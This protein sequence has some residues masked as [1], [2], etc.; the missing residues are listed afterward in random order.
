METNSRL[1]LA[2]DQYDEL[3]RIISV[4][5]PE[6]IVTYSKLN[7][8]FCIKGKDMTIRRTITE[9][10]LYI[11]PQAIGMEVI[12]VN[13]AAP[14]I[15]YDDIVERVQLLKTSEGKEIAAK[16]ENLYE[17]CEAWD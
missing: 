2:E 9:V 11:I 13:T 4:L 16:N 15:L 12:M 8:D 5:Y 3:S 14:S 10:L 1:I 17:R 7:H 6:A